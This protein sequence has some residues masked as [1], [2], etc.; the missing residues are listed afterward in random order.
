[1]LTS[2]PV[3]NPESALGS[4]QD[5]L[6][7]LSDKPTMI[8]IHDALRQHDNRV[9]DAMDRRF[10]PH[11]ESFNHK[12]KAILAA[13]RGNYSAT[14]VQWV[15]EQAK[16]KAKSPKGIGGLILSMLRR[17]QR[18]ARN[19]P[20]V[21]KASYPAAIEHLRHA[22]DQLGLG[23]EAKYA[24][25]ID[26][27]TRRWAPVTDHLL[28]HVYPGASASDL[29]NWCLNKGN[30][31]SSVDP[32]C[33]NPGLIMSV[34]KS[35]MGKI[36]DDWDAAVARGPKDTRPVFTLPTECKTIATGTGL[37]ITGNPDNDSVLGPMT[38]PWQPGKRV[39]MMLA[40]QDEK[41]AAEKKM[42]D[43]GFAPDGTPYAVVQI[44]RKLAELRACDPCM[45]PSHLGTLD[46]LR[47]EIEVNRK[48]DISHG[49]SRALDD[50]WMQTINRETEDVFSDLAGRGLG[51]LEKTGQT[52]DPMRA[53][54]EPVIDTAEPDP[55]ELAAA[56]ASVNDT[57]ARNPAV[58]AIA[59]RG[60][61][62]PP[63]PQWGAEE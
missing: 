32:E 14:D 49:R 48:A 55:D 44:R 4:G 58:P 18:P 51:K 45:V 7:D 50:K 57:L 15:I 41:D 25:F 26:R 35:Q 52:A 11:F 33:G 3:E 22:L 13:L 54:A 23:R 6:S 47:R 37:I 17:G 42:W 1:M 53:E 12:S 9:K 61:M 60:G 16:L 63:R 19:A 24:G 40:A 28:R 21:H 56:F 46:V 39:Q 34:V 10:Q 8:E 43:T 29:L 20:I 38:D 62:N 36:A 27:V 31:Y 59:S 5:L 30:E 2:R